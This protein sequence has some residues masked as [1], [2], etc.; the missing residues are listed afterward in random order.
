MAETEDPL[1]E[2]IDEAILEH[3][4][5]GVDFPASREQISRFARALYERGW[6]DG[7]DQGCFECTGGQ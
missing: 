2:M 7:Y 6:E 1:C 4:L 3:W 5:G